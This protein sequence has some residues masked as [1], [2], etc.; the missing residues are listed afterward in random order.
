MNTGLEGKSVIVTGGA[1]GI[2]YAA[3]ELLASAGCAVTIADI[4]EAAGRQR[5]AQLERSGTGK[6]QFIRTDVSREADVQAMVD[7]AVAAFGRLDGAINCAGVPPRNKPLHEIT[8]D[9][10]DASDGI[11]L[12]GMFL[13]FK[14]EIMAMLKTGGGSIVGISSTAATSAVPGSAEYCATKSGVNGLVRGAALDYADK[15]IRINGV[16]PGAT[17]TP[18]FEFATRSVKMN[19]MSGSLPMKRIG[20]PAEVAAGAVW[21]ISDHASYVTGVI[22]PVDG[23]LTAV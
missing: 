18:M 14:Y 1:S 5:S 19:D 9:H 23:G 8:T 21:L 22:L 2:G 11:N 10:W 6:V 13:C 17:Q 4:D 12:R 15:G 16:M 20:A 3:V 7:A